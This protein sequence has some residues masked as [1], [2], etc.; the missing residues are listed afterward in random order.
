MVTHLTVQFIHDLDRKRFT[1]EINWSGPIP[2]VGSVITWK[3]DAAAPL[4]YTSS[5]W[6]VTKAD[7][8][9][10]LDTSDSQ[11]AFAEVSHV[12]LVAHYALT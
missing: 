8:I 5:Q 4:E 7:F 3:L 2:T 12:N 9:T 1:R 6:T 10:R 11:V